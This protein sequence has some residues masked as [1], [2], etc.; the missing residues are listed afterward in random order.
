M[1]NKIYQDPIILQ[2]LEE[3]P[4]AIGIYEGPDLRFVFINKTG[5]LAV[6]KSKEEVMGKTYAEVLPHAKE[7]LA[8]IKRVYETGEIF[9]REEM[10]LPIGFDDAGKPI[11]E[12]V[13]ML[14]QPVKNSEG[15][16]IGVASFG[17]VVTAS[18]MTKKKLSEQSSRTL[19]ILNNL[20]TGFF[21]VDRNWIFTYSN[22]AAT[23]ALGLPPQEILG[24]HVWTVHPHLV[25]TEFY[26]AYHRSMNERVVVEVT[27]YYPAQDKWYHTTSYP[28]DE[29]IAVSFT[30]I[31]VR[32]KAEEARALS[33]ERFHILTEAMPQ[34][35]WITDADAMAYYFNKRWCEQTGTAYEEN[36]GL[37]WLKVV[38][39]DDQAT[40][41]K[42]WKEAQITKSYDIEYR[43]RMHDGEYRWHVARGIPTIGDDQKIKQW[44]GTTTD[45]HQQKI[46]QVEL[47]KAVRARDEFLSI[48]SHELKTPMTVIRLQTQFASRVL[49]NESKPLDRARMQ[50]FNNTIDRNII[51][52]N[53][54]VDDMLDISR[55]EHG[56]FNV[57]LEKINLKIMMDEVVDRMIPFFE[58]AHCKL[59][60]QSR[61]DIFIMIDKFRMEQVLIN[62]FT[63]AARYGKGNPVQ[64]SYKKVN[65]KAIISV[66]DHG[67][68]IA[69]EDQTRIF[70][71]F[72]RATDSNDVSGLGLGLFIVKKIVEIHHGEVHVHSELGQG[73]E[74]VI[75][76]PIIDE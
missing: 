68:G 71:R 21:S 59:E 36:L 28:L 47:T 25:G 50:T 38:H 3:A 70:D 16:I 48:A 23:P 41:E 30:D 54:L 33:D 45:I 73:S 66:K 52:L 4:I 1:L 10:A 24:K 43:V 60:Y 11:V 17:T 9:S 22:P 55:I 2:I 13:N 42:A 37:G 5:A 35:V 29:G 7:R 39:P 74:F 6:H 46:T 63:N 18:V 49:D 56:K 15:K 65:L 61:E 51:R 57:E 64:V 75:S 31:T 32:K 26:H 67:P 69:K 76:L 14:S 27:N 53:R 34:M 44:Y 8:T 19:E 20:S 12:Y 62:L 40:A 58:D 72:E